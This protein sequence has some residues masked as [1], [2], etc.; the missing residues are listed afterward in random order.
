MRKILKKTLNGLGWLLLGLLMLFASWAAFN[1]P[2]ADAAAKPRPQALMPVPMPVGQP[3]AYALLLDPNTHL[4]LPSAAP[5][6]CGTSGGDCTQVWLEQSAKLREQLKPTSQF[7]PV[8]EAASAEGVSW[9]EPARTLPEEDPAAA[10]IPQFKNV[11][12]CLQWLH[13]RAILAALDGQDALALRLLQRAD[14]STRGMLDGGQTL[15]GHAIAWS[16]AHQQWQAVAAVARTRPQLASLLL[17]MLRPLDAAALSTQRWVADEALF[18]QAVMRDMPR[19]CLRLSEASEYF[20]GWLERFWC[21]GTLGFL[22]ELSAQQMDEH[23]LQLVE[24]TRN[25]AAQWAAT[26]P[27]ET[28]VAEPWAWRNSVGRILVEV[29][30][31]N[32]AI[33]VNKQAEVELGRQ[34]A[35]LIVRM[36][37]EHVPAAQRQSWLQAQ[38][39]PPE[40]KGRFSIQQDQLLAKP[41]REDVAAARKLTF[42]LSTSP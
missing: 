27:K 3:S 39:L 12:A 8:C 28:P 33:Y 42:S 22:P 13:A 7:T 32:W 2:W 1:G 24:Q 4:D 20:H 25:G 23:F 40:T 30:R 17:A 34:A 26:R 14:R 36:S 18:S 19:S 29:A 41:W 5:W 6:R 35:E 10:P 31:P 16:I 37:G 11:M 21:H 38:P 15:I 9:V